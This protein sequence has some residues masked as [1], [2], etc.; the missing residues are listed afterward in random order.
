M[1]LEKINQTG[2]IKEL[3]SQDL[4]A[5]SKEIRSFLIK[6]LSETGGHLSSNLGVVELTIALHR[7][8]DFPEDKLI[9][10]VGHQC[11][12][13]KILT[14]RKDAFSGIRQYGGIS[15]FP[16]KCESVT[17]VFE[18]GH[19][20][21]S[22]SAGLGL[23]RARDLS[24]ADYKVVSVIGDGA[25]SGGE[26]YEALNNAAKLD[27]NFIIILNDNEMSI[28][29]STGGISRHLNSMR[30]AQG[31]LNLRDN[32]YHSLNQKSKSKVI[33]GIR[34]AKNSLKS[35]VVPGMLFENLGLTYLGPVDGHD[36][37]QLKTALEAASRVRKAVVLHVITKKGKGYQPAEK[38]PARFH[39]TA[40]FLIE[41][42]VPVKRTKSA[43]QD[44]FSTVMC[45]QGERD[46]KVVCITAAME[47]GTGLKRFHNMFPER[48][49]DVGIAEQHAVTF[50]AG[51]ALGGY[52]PIFAVY[53]TFL[54]RAYDQIIDDVC[55]Q[56]LPVVF[57]VDRA[58][59]VGADGE[60]H[61]GIFDLSYL[62]TIPNL[63]VMAPKNKWELSDMIK[64]ALV[65]H[66]P[67]AIRYPRGEAWDGLQEYRNEIILGKAEVIFDESG[68]TSNTPEHK[69][70]D[71]CLFAIGSMVKTATQV[72]AQLKSAGY[73]CSL[74]NARFAAP[75]DESCIQKMASTHKV[76]V[77]MEEN[78]SDGGFGERVASMLNQTALHT[79]VLQMAVP[80]KFIPHGAPDRLLHDIGLDSEGIYRKII[81]CLS[82][83]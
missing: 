47:D 32:I 76:I 60:T 82:G 1:F 5:L 48:F 31:Y 33:D 55:M 67:I 6:S 24:G 10:D 3:S 73:S 72:R 19:A 11:Y 59:I 81:S 4:P 56:D 79:Q 41:N 36:F 57:A 62:C 27:S 42:G 16:K 15:G 18:T 34:R 43:Y 40:P 37:T 2:D 70:A 64:F 23:V 66:H 14:G 65:F 68:D 49:F 69:T 63:T 12:T 71:V 54:Q 46:E 74:V 30:T 77:T 8:L 21:N 45:K 25:L 51:L 58:G 80:K 17:D 38:H 61:Q 26:A 22:I 53:S 13:H 7:F 9:W 29:E 83:N 44:I 75:F 20:S 50:A 78:V 39:G 28:S 35:L 52:K